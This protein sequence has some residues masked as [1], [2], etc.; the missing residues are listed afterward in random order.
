MIETI[1]PGLSA[2][3][4]VHPMLVHFPIAF[5][6][7]AVAM[8]GLAVFRHER[9]HV[10]ATWMLYLGTLSA[11]VTAPTGFVAMNSIAAAE[12]GGP[13][14]EFIH[15]H[16]NWMVAVTL[17]GTS[18]SAYLVWI[19]RRGTWASHRWALFSGLVLLGALV[20]L[21]ADRGARLVFAFGVGV[22]SEVIREPVPA[23]EYRGDGH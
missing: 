8:E 5:F 22:N 15:V 10:V 11:L 4:N 19:T 23:Q 2:I 9:F 14:H 16:R 1:L 13:D 7:G 3:Q 21:G 17:L 6:L 20:I 12:S 18:L